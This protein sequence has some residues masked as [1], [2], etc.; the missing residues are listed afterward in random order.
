DLITGT[1]TFP[2]VT[3]S[4]TYTT[5]NPDNPNQIVVTYNDSRTAPNNYSGGSVST[6]GGTT[7]TRLTPNPFSTGHG[8]NFGDPVTLYNKPSSTFFAVFIATGCGGQGL[9]SWK[10]TDGGVTW[11]TGACVHTGSFDDRESGWS[12]NN[13]S[14]PFFGRMF[15]SWNDFNVGSG[16]LRVTFST[17]NG[18]TWHA[19]INVS[20]TATFIR[21][22]QIT[23]DLSGN[24]TIYIA[25]MDEG[26]G[27]FP[28]NNVN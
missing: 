17:D 6:N 3:Q 27:G 15:V 5:A 9:G 19:P 10:S 28:H 21:D 8:T 4:E 13:P 12:D 18:A 25:G 26:S 14:S 1:E 7:F 2:S 23:G 20:N 22:V 16:A 24:G 11:A